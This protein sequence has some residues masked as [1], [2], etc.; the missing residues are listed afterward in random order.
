MVMVM[1]L[2]GSGFSSGSELRPESRS[3]ER[4]D[5]E[6][7]RKRAVDTVCPCVSAAAALARSYFRMPSL[8]RIAT[9]GMKS[10][11][12]R[13]STAHIIPAYHG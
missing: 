3:S 11:E 5:R 8:R 1:G 2:S 4:V 7:P 9:P 10:T 12:E 6:L 13:T